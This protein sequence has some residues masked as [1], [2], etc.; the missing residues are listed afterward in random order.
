MKGYW[1]RPR[2][3]AGAIQGGR[4]YTGDI[5]YLDADG[6]LYILDRKKD[7]VFVGAHNVFPGKVEKVI[8]E[9]PHVDEVAVVGLPDTYF[10]HRLRAFVTMRE[11]APDLTQRALEDFLSGKLAMYEIP[12]E[13]EV[14]TSLP[15][16][17]VGKLAKQEL[18]AESIAT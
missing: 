10:G 1:K 7:M 8:G 4:L 16:T 12:T 9:H 5:G 18:L 15:K 11:G 6:Y 17:A 13:L 3:T 2:E 14:R